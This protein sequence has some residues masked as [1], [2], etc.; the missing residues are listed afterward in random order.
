MLI[1]GD[2]VGRGFAVEIEDR[3]LGLSE[4]RRAELNELLENP[5]PF[6]L[7]GSDQLGL[8]VA[9]QLAK[10]HSIRISLRSS[11]YGGT[12]AIVLIPLIL[13]VPEDGYDEAEAGT[14]RPRGGAADRPARGPGRRRHLRRPPGRRPAG[15]PRPRRRRR[16]WRSAEAR[17]ATRGRSGGRADQPRGYP[18]C[19]VPSQPAAGPAWPAAASRR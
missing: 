5:P 8:F 3:G 4:E 17:A 12:T 13:V 1:T 16:T 6:D 2:V 18:A 11:P 9:S 14:G 19:P 10:K 15:S 7:S